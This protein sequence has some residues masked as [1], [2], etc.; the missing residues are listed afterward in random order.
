[1]ELLKLT[2]RKRIDIT[3]HVIYNASEYLFPINGFRGVICAV[4]VSVE[5]RDGL[6]LIHRLEEGGVWFEI[7]KIR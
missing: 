1:M 3:L 6:M 4:S 2:N 7:G 5:A